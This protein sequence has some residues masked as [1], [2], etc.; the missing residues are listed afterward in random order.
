MTPRPA[1]LSVPNWRH[2]FMVCF[3]CN[4]KIKDKELIA[5]A[6]VG[7]VF[8]TIENATFSLE[9]LSVGHI[10]KH[11]YY[12]HKDCFLN[13]SCKNDALAKKLQNSEMT[14]ED[15]KYLNKLAGISENKHEDEP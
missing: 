9:A 1:N 6:N 10:R 5:V 12:F 2:Q 7:Q 15:W 8:N 3:S 13:S 4:E 11:A 14:Q